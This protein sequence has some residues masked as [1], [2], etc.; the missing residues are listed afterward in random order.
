MGNLEKIILYGC[1]NIFQTVVDIIL[2]LNQFEITEIWDGDPNKIGKECNIGKVSK[3]IKTP[4]EDY[5][6]EVVVIT[7]TLYEEEIRTK[8]QEQYSIHLCRIKPWNYCFHNIKEEIINKYKEVKDPNIIGILQYLKDKEL[9]VFNR[10]DLELDKFPLENIQVF[11]DN[12]CEMYYTLWD[13]KKMF[14]KRGFKSENNVKSYIRSIIMEQSEF[15]PHCY[16]KSGYES[17]A[18][19]IIVDGGAAEGFFALERIDQ[20]KKV[21]LIEADEEWNEALEKTFAPYK[22]KVQL[23]HN[24]IGDQETEI[25]LDDIVKEDGSVL[26][27]LDIEGNEFSALKSSLRFLYRDS[28][29]YIIACTYHGSNDAK[30]IEGIL[31]QQGYHTVF[32]AGYMFFPF[33][34]KIE[35]KLRHGLIFADKC[36]S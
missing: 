24:R 20:V 6:N 4:G 28:N 25:S 22:D 19:D 32:S 36:I 31:R 2:K 13:G 18:V 30:E 14:F 3:K 1:G 8:L 12:A 9:T 7:S 5:N 27:K 17:K 16:R 10:P 29:I 21:Y 33:G 34:E 23:I 15:S 26:I 35:A 11:W